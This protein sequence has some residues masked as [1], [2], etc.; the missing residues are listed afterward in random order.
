MNINRKCV[1]PIISH[2]TRPLIPCIKTS[3][4]KEIKRR[5]IHRHLSQCTKTLKL[6]PVWHILKE[7]DSRGIHRHSSRCAKRMSNVPPVVAPYGSHLIYGVFQ[8]TSHSNC[9]QSC[10]AWEHLQVSLAHAPP[11]P[12]TPPLSSMQENRRSSCPSTTLCFARSMYQLS[13][14][15]RH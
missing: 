6:P 3:Q 9:I 13:P 15:G 5:A 7:I 1:P 8:L 12:G 10:T 11:M 2:G 14:W 4:P